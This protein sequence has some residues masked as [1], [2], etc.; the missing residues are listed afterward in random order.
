MEITYSVYALIHPESL[1]VIY[2]GVTKDIRTRLNA[3]R[4]VYKKNGEPM[5]LITTVE[6]FTNVY[7][8][9]EYEFQ[10]ITEYK[11]IGHSIKNSDK[12]NPGRVLTSQRR[13]DR[14]RL[15]RLY[16]ELLKEHPEYFVK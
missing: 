14:K 8:A 5:P 15:S 11:S 4:T 3:H 2:I 13:I 7:D 6:V 1:E 16:P 9:E 10:L 12:R